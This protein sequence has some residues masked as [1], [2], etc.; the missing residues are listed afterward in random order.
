M[1]ATQRLCQSAVESRN[2]ARRYIDERYPITETLTNIFGGF[3]KRN[4]QRSMKRLA[5]HDTLSGKRVEIVSE[6]LCGTYPHIQYQ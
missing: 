3:K 4:A 6:K 5:T 2:E 1:K